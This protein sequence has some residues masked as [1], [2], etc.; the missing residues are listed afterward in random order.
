[1]IFQLQDGDK[2]M[3]QSIGL[4]E[5]HGELIGERRETSDWLEVL[6]IWVLSLLALGLFLE[7]HGLRM[8][9]ILPR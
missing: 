9:E 2:K 5:I 7:I 6:I 8:K 1:M 4:L 3:E